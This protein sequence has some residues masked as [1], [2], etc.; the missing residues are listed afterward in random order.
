MCLFFTTNPGKGKIHNLRVK[1]FYRSK[2]KRISGKSISEQLKNK[3]GSEVVVYHIPAFIVVTGYLEP[4]IIG[5]MIRLVFFA[6]LLSMILFVLIAI[7][8][9]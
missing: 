2:W 8:E 7:R 5:L 9:F 4:F 6:G 3:F 1:S